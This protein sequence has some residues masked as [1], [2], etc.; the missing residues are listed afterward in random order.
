[1]SKEYVYKHQFEIRRPIS[2]GELWKKVARVNLAGHMLANL[3]TKYNQKFFNTFEDLIVEEVQNPEQE[4]VVFIC[5]VYETREND[6]FGLEQN[7]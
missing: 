7:K 3:N 6:V 2:C 4:Q 5:T 1:M